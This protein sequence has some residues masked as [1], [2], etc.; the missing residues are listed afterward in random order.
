MRRR[1]VLLV[2]ALLLGTTLLAV[3]PGVRD[4]IGRLANYEA[5]GRDP[6]YD[7][8]IDG[9]AIRRGGALLPN[10]ATYYVDA[11]ADDPLLAGNLKAAAQLFFVPALPV[12]DVSRAE[13]VLTHRPPASGRKTHRLGERLF[14]VER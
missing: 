10:E 12:R 3:V 11:P 9:R 4:P 7:A 5:D 14:L 6:L 13:W 8:A 1:E 2:L